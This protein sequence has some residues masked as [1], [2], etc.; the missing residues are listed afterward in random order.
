MDRAEAFAFI[1]DELRL[2]SESAFETFSASSLSA[3]TYQA[4][5]KFRINRQSPPQIDNPSLSFLFLNCSTCGQGFS[6]LMKV[7]RQR[8]HSAPVINARIEQFIIRIIG[9]IRWCLHD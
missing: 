1:M 6:G 4:R 2:M 8:R 5:N 3:R 9:E 7:W